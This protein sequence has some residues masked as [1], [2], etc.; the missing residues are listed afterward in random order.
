MLEGML[1]CNWRLRPPIH[2][3]VAAALRWKVDEWII[4][5]IEPSNYIAYTVK[6]SPPPPYSPAHFSTHHP[7]LQQDPGI[8]EAL[9]I[10]CTMTSISWVQVKCLPWST[11]CK[12]SCSRVSMCACL[13]SQHSVS[14]SRK[15][16]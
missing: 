16:W 11:K 2:G 1:Q 10:T 5:L 15:R 8:W 4:Y 7:L 9:L 13:D 3:V 6:V 12:L 14:S